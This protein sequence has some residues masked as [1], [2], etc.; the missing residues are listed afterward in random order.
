MSQ[1]KQAF[2]TLT[3]AATV[4]VDF[5]VSNNNQ[6]TVAGNRTLTFANPAVGE[7]Y[8]VRITQDAS[9]SRTI[10]WPTIKWAGGSAPS[11]TATASRTDDVFLMYDGTFYSD[12]A[13]VKNKTLA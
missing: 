1:A 13:I 4:A 2:V 3:D 8:C 10:T 6:V 11:L 7:I 5:S 12:V 9:G